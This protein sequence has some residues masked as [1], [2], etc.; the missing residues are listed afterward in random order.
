M[1]ESWLARHILPGKAYYYG[2]IGQ[3]GNF[4]MAC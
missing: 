1:F 2:L 3:R 4:A